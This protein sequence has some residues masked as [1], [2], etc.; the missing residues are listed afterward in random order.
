M[1]KEILIFIGLIIIIVASL[2]YLARPHK[3]IK[4][5]AAK[6]ASDVLSIERQEQ[7]KIEQN[8]ERIKNAKRGE[9]NL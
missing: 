8:K 9:W 2:W 7:E 3:I 5:D 6:T 1:K 4:V